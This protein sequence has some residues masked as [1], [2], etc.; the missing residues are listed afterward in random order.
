MISV[1]ENQVKVI[2]FKSEDC[3][4]QSSGKSML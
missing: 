1:D 4:E 2:I 3:K